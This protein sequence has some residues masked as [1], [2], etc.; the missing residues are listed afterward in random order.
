MTDAIVLGF[1]DRL[2]EA[3]AT[4]GRSNHVPKADAVFGKAT[5]PLIVGEPLQLLTNGKAEQA[6]ELV[7]RVRVITLGC[8]RRVSGQAAEDE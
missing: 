3:A 6:P 1:A 4:T 2:V 5:Q 7:G 8:E